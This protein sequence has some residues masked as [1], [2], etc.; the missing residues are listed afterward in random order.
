VARKNALS[1]LLEATKTG[2]YSLFMSLEM[3]KFGPSVADRPTEKNA[4]AM[5][6]SPK[7]PN[8]KPANAAAPKL[9]AVIKNGLTEQEMD[10]AGQRW[11]NHQ[12]PYMTVAETLAYAAKRDKTLSPDQG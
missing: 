10:E 5:L 12:G 6:K 3:A 2:Y 8:K 1:W 4:N 9:I 7:N 11:V